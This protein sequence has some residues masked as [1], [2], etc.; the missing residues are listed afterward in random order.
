MIDPFG[1]RNVPSPY[2]APCQ[3]QTAAPTDYENLLADA[4]EAAFADGAWDLPALI[5]RLNADGLRAPDGTVWTEARF[6]VEMQ[7]LGGA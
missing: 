2:L 4:I 6:R 1:P 5:A 3:A 7:R